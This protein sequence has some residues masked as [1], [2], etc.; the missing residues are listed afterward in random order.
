MVAVW[1]FPAPAAAFGTALVHC[2]YRERH[3][4]HSFDPA[5]AHLGAADELAD[6]GR[7]RGL[8]PLDPTNPHVIGDLEERRQ[9]LGRQDRARP[10]PD[11][12]RADLPG[13]AV[14]TERHKS[15]LGGREQ[16][17]P[18]RRALGADPVHER[19]VGRAANDTELPF[20]HGPDP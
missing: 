20:G 10:L 16:G 5:E 3:F 17:R 14:R 7:G 4:D 19:P 1:S 15:S 18:V 8:V 12:V 6:R 13:P 2:S 9:V 11:P